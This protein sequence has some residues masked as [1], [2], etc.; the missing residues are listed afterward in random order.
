M[1]N[2]TRIS[3]KKDSDLRQVATIICENLAPLIGCNINSKKW[4]PATAFRVCEPLTVVTNGELTNLPK[5]VYSDDLFSYTFLPSV[6]SKGFEIYQK[7]KAYDRTIMDEYYMFSSTNYFT[8]SMDSKTRLKII[9]STSILYDSTIF[10]AVYKNPQLVLT[11][12]YKQIF[13]ILLYAYTIRYY[14]Y[15]YATEYTSM[16]DIINMVNIEA[17][18]SD[19]EYV[20]L[21]LLEM[22]M[23]EVGNSETSLHFICDQLNVLVR[24]LRQIN[25]ELLYYLK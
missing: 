6:T 24:S 1:E 15:E 22:P 11:E 9:A 2:T 18:I 21:T 19:I 4:S 13:M 23:K 16:S 7:V 25:S 5:R 8:T 20:K 3:T 10:T 17:L 14:L 12:Q